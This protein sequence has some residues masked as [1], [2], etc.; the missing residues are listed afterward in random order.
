[1]TPRPH[2]IRRTLLVQLM[3]PMLLVALVAG[4]CAYSVASHFSQVILDQW[5]HDSA[6][7]LATRVRWDGE[8]AS[9]DL[10]DDIRKIL[11][12]DT[13]DR[14]FYEVTGSDGTRIGGN[15]LLP[16]LPSPLTHPGATLRYEGSTND[17]RVRVIAL[18]LPEHRGT[19]VVVK[20][21]ETQQKRSALARQLFWMS[22][23]LSLV[24]A[25]LSA[26]FIWYGIG[27]GIASIEQA[28]RGVRRQDGG[29]PL[30]PIRTDADMPVE[31]FP[32][33][34]QINDLL[35]DLVAAQRLNER[36]IVNAAHQLRTPVATLRVRLEMASRE[37]DAA[38]RAEAIADSIRVVSHMTRMLHQLLMLARAD[39]KAIGPGGPASADIDL[40]ARE[41]VE[42]RLDD[43]LALAV[44]L[45]YEG[46]GEPTLVAG[47]ADLIRE[48][49]ANLL[50]NALRYGSSGGQIT[51]GVAGAPAPAIHV[52]DH[53]PGIPAAER[54]RVTERFQR[55]PGTRGEGCGLGLAIVH[56]IA[57]L[58]QATLRLE[59][60]HDGSGL[61]AT[62]AFA[63]AAAI[64]VE[65]AGA[66]AAPRLLPGEHSRSSDGWMC[67]TS[68]R[69]R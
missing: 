53:G 19:S 34:E 45:G 28:V 11:E 37:P 16:P 64:D 41:E 31:V 54:E 5:L 7:S 36:F 25:G 61:R 14:V 51:V 52:E 48:A 35:A 17:S 22:L 60:R 24:L 3:G 50:D 15:A 2:S 26:T 63:P 49:V 18:A 58:F 13:I 12:T 68:S 38:R 10:T 57:A 65:S 27:R 20:V 29:A 9:V 21:A 1:M 66:P 55:L 32:L 40:I 43:A 4:A 30:A 69:R 59:G 62:V 42:R 44:D 67:C 46:P 6:I 23:G 56:E 39:E 47:N 8:R 33:V